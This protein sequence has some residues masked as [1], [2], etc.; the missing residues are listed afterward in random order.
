MRPVSRVSVVTLDDDK[1]STV[2]TVGGTIEETRFTI[3]VIVTTKLRSSQEDTEIMC[4]VDRNKFGTPYLT[5]A[6]IYIKVDD[7]VYVNTGPSETP[8]EGGVFQLAF[9]VPEQYPFQPPQVSL[10][11]SILLNGSNGLAEARLPPCLLSPGLA[12]SPEERKKVAIIALDCQC[13]VVAKI[14]EENENQ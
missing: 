8:Y 7:D 1:R 3:G 13:L 6:C 9:S 11:G 2:N 5:Q 12:L 10:N 4:L 14:I